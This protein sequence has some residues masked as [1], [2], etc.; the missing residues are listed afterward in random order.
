MLQGFLSQRCQRNSETRFVL[1][2]LQSWPGIAYYC[3]TRLHLGFSAKLRIWQV[4]ACKMEPQSDYIMQS[5]PATQPPH[6]LE[7]RILSFFFQCCMVSLSTKY[8]QSLP[9]PSYVFLCC[10]LP[11]NTWLQL[12]YHSSSTY[13]SKCGTPSLACSPIFVEV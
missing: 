9:L 10:V 1:L 8:V 11:T 13:I 6:Q 3:H 5:G 12:N 4:P 2:E 7:I